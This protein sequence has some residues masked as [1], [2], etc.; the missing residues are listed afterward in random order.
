VRANHLDNN[1]REIVNKLLAIGASV[2]QLNKVSDGCPDL[3]IWYHNYFLF[4]VKNPNAQESKRRQL[5]PAEKRWHSKWRGPI[6][7]VE[8]FEEI[9]NIMERNMRG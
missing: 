7:I 5:T 4:E 3:L 6:H 9:L 1:Q 2:Q 8:T